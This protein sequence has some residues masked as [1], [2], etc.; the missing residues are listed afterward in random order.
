MSRILRSCAGKVISRLC[1]ISLHSRVPGRYPLMNFGICTAVYVFVSFRLFMLTGDLKNIAIP[2][3]DPALLAR[4]GGIM[5]LGAGALY[6]AGFVLMS[7]L[8]LV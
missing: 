6:A 7:M 4:N 5:L 2:G 1:H 8:R 3:K